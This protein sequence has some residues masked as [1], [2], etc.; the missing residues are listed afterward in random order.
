MYAIRSYYATGG[1]VHYWFND[2]VKIGATASQDDEENVDNRLVGA[3]VTLRKSAASWI[4]LEAGH[5]KGPG[6]LATNSVD[7]GFGFGTVGSLLDNTAE[8]PAYRVDASY[9]FV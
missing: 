8:A 5:T 9:N 3:D 7:G 2:Y 6:V 1:R 4:K